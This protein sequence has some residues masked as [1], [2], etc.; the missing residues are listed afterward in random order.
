MRIP[1]QASLSSMLTQ[2]PCTIS[3]CPHIKMAG[4]S[5]VMTL[6]AT[7]IK[8][9]KKMCIWTSIAAVFRN[10]GGKRCAKDVRVLT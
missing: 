2:Q 10:F 3:I 5:A 4:R 8:D 1:S 7:N 6:D 9:F